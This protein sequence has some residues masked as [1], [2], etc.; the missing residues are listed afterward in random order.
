MQLTM[1]RFHEVSAEEFARWRL[2]RT[3]TLPVPLNGC[4]AARVVLPTEVVRDLTGDEA[5]SRREAMPEW[6]PGVSDAFDDL[7][8]TLSDLSWVVFYTVADFDAD[9]ETMVVGL[10]GGGGS[11]VLVAEPTRIR[12]AQVS[13]SEVVSTAVA[14]LPTMRAA[15]I[16]P[17]HITARDQK[18]IDDMRDRR[19]GDRVI[20]AAHRAAGFSDDDLALLQR[21]AQGATGGG[22]LGA[23]VY[24]DQ[25]SVPGPMSGGWVSSPHGAFLHTLD[26]SGLTIFE[27]ATAASL[28]R[29]GIHAVAAAR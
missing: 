19:A 10:S 7:R 3:V 18:K 24:S 29:A 17:V 28:T 27:A 1:T 22:M 26:E 21:I 4:A 13:D 15:R 11:F 20:K 8:T 6:T 12:L 25:G 14:Q 9:T 5:W 2:G 23:A 16:S